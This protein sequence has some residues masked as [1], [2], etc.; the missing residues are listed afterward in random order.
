MLGISRHCAKSLYTENSAQCESFESNFFG[1]Q[2]EDYSPGDGIS[3]STVKLLQTVGN[4]QCICDFCEMG[5]HAIKYI[6]LQKVA[7]SFMKVTDNHNE[8]F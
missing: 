7:A 6:F 2:N 4:K 5:V 1:G 8:G 3:D